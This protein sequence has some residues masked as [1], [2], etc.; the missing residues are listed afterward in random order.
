[1]L[2]QVSIMDASNAFEQ[3]KLSFVNVRSLKEYQ[4]PYG[5]EW[6]E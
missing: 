6:K 1:M 3:Q 2:I 5:N 4:M